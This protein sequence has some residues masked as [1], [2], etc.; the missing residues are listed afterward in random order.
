M[1][2]TDP[3]ELRRQVDSMVEPLR[4]RP[5]PTVDAI[6]H[7]NEIAAQEYGAAV[8]NPLMLWDLHWLKELDDEGFIDRLVADLSTRP[9]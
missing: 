7:T 6:L 4:L 3:A 9:A 1:K 2:I 5:Y 8:D